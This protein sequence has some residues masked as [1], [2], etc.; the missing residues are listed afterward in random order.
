MKRLVSEVIG[1]FLSN[2]ARNGIDCPVAIL[3]TPDV[4]KRICGEAGFVGKVPM[5]EIA[6]HAGNVVIQ[7]GVI[8]RIER[9]SPVN[10]V[11]PADA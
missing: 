2:M 5:F 9:P 1:D 8:Q 4:Y 6:G 10:A 3:L 11:P 7:A